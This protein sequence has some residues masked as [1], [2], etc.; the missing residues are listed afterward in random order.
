M[1]INSTAAMTFPVAQFL[2]DCESVKNGAIDSIN[3]ESLV[4]VENNLAM[5]M[6]HIR[7]VRANR[8]AAEPSPKMNR[9]QR[10]DYLSAFVKENDIRSNDSYERVELLAVYLKRI[11]F[12]SMSTSTI[13]IIHRFR[14]IA[15][16]SGGK[17]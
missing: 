14:R 15:E 16:K 12:Y 7:G 17:P 11:G 9:Q 13:D 8:A 4:L 3:S 10:H 1:K 2:R 5:A 6:M